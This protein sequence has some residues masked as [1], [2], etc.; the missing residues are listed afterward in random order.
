MPS[1]SITVEL[2]HSDATLTVDGSASGRLRGGDT[3]TIAAYERRLELV[4]FS[5]PE[6]F[7]SVLRAKLG[8]GLPLVPYPGRHPKPSGC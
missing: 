8:W 1:R 6:R 7:Y 3:V 5:P 2:P 4:R